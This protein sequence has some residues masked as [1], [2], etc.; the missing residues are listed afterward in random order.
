LLPPSPFEPLLGKPT[1]VDVSAQGSAGPV[2]EGSQ[3]SISIQPS[4]IENAALFIEC[5]YSYDLP[6][7][8]GTG[9]TGIFRD[10]LKNAIETTRDHSETTYAQFSKLLL[11]QPAPQS[12][13]ASK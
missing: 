6:S 5:K 4:S 10:I 11:K 3:V 9:S 13:G 7:D 8:E 1:V 12:K 2:P